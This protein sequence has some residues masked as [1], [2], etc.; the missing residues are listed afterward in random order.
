L[1]IFG[2]LVISTV[3]NKVDTLIIQRITQRIT[4][5]TKP[6]EVRQSKVGKIDT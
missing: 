6:F 3:L 5:T 2:T 4:D 1:V